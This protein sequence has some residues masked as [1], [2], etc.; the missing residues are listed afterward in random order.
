MK[1]IA[2]GGVVLRVRAGVAE[3]ALTQIG[4]RDSGRG[5]V[6]AALDKIFEAFHQVDGSPSQMHAGSGLG[7]AIVWQRAGAMGGAV[8]TRSAGPGGSCFRLD[9]PVVY[10]PVPRPRA[11]AEVWVASASPGHAA[12]LAAAL[13]A[14]LNG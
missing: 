12:A 6:N 2:R 8:R 1:F 5:L 10:Y 4:V 11:S 14:R 3:N 13:R 7:L 9:W